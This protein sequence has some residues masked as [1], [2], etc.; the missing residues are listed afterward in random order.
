MVFQ[1]LSPVRLF[2]RGFVRVRRDP[3]Q[4]IELGVAHG[5]DANGDE[6]QEHADEQQP[7]FEDPHDRSITNKIAC[8]G[9]IRRQHVVRPT[10][11]Y[12][13]SVSVSVDGRTYQRGSPPQ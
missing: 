13:V 9:E 11:I 6:S 5:R 7:S 2:D 1:R 4:V 10:Y 12:T 8:L 3:Q